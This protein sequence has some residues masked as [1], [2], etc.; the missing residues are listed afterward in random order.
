[1]YLIGEAREA[2]KQIVCRHHY[3]RSVPSG[4]SHWFQIEDA[5]ICFSIPA[6][7]NIDRFLLGRDGNV[8]E[9]SR[10]WAAAFHEPNLL[11]RAI[12]EAVKGR[13]QVEPGV[14]A[15]VS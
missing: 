14:E 11:T 10:M 5:F 15:L 8:W 1:M 9:L 13:K 6:N 3:S 2:A 4:K 7:R 12:A